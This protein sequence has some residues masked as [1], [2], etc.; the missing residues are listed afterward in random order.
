MLSQSVGYAAVALGIMASAKGKPLLVR[1][2][3]S[4]GDIPAPYLAKLIH[5]LGR[6]GVV[7]TQRGI[8]GGVVLKKKAEELSLYDLCLIYDDP[9]INV[10]CMLGNSVCSVERACPLHAFWVAERR[11]ILEFVKKTTIANLKD[12][13]KRELI[14]LGRNV[15][16]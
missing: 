4:A 2:I 12:F 5:I 8:G 6:K 7:A 10:E 3:A 11:R 13:E 1:D 16:K 9:I 14:R 15:G